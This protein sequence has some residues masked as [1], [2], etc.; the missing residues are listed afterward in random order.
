[1]LRLTRAWFVTS[2]LLLGLLV[3]GCGPGETPQDSG[4]D[5]PSDAGRDAASPDSGRC[6]TVCESGRACCPSASGDMCVDLSVDV[7]NCG[8]CGRDCVALRRGDHCEDYQCSC[9][10]AEVGCTGGENSTCCPPRIGGAEAYCA[11]TGRDPSDCGECGFSCIPERANQCEG[12]SCTC[13]LSGE[14]CAGTP[15]DLCCQR[16]AEDYM[17]VDTTTSNDHCGFCANRCNAN[18]QCVAGICESTLPDAGGRDAGTDAGTDAG[19]D[20]GTDA[21]EDAATETDAGVDAP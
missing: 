11:N 6:G 9:G 2:L 8:V 17:C 13:G 12:G 16:D 7:T 14:E 18:E 3:P 20:A 19:L 21:G 15:E 4:V 5:A 1:V 10:S